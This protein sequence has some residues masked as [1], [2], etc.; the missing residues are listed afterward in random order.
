MVFSDVSAELVRTR[1]PC[2]GWSALASFP[3][4]ALEPTCY[5]V[6]ELGLRGTDVRERAQSFLLHAQNPNGSWPAFAGDDH[7]GTWVTSLQCDS[8]RACHQREF[9]ICRASMSVWNDAEI[10]LVK[11][12]HTKPYKEAENQDGE[13]R[14]PATQAHLVSTRWTR[15]A[16]GMT[17]RREQRWV[18]WRGLVSEEEQSSQS[19]AA[20]CGACGLSRS[21]FYCWKRRLQEASRPQ[22]VEAQVVKANPDK[23]PSRQCWDQRLRC[24]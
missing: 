6:L 13:W 23:R 8:I 20:F 4:P 1:L 2:G 10:I 12:A 15:Q 7:D 22:L 24:G 3:Q 18:K 14:A 5:S 19:V 11:K 17:E 16:F 21:Y 9:W